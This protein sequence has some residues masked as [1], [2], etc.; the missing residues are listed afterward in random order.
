TSTTS[1]AGS[2]SRSFG[3]STSSSSSS[4]SRSG[5]S[6]PQRRRPRTDPVLMLPRCRLRAT[7]D[8][9][10]P[11]H[12]GPGPSR[13]GLAADLSAA[14]RLVLLSSVLL[15]LP[16]VLRPLHVEGALGVDALVGVRTEVVALGLHQGG[17]QT[18]R[19]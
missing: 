14:E 18:L 15:R 5:S 17:R 12:H 3:C 8:Q 9:K 16:A 1:G 10:G 7:S 4:C 2:S 13:S 6:V 19:A 11:D